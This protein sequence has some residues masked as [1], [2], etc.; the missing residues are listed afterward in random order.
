MKKLFW[1]LVIPLTVIFFFSIKRWTYALVIDAPATILNGF[2]FISSAEAWH[3]SMAIQI[4]IL[5]FISNFFIFLTLIFLIIY[6]VHK[7]FKITQINKWI[8]IPLWI[9]T[10][11][12][13]I[14][15]PIGV[16]IFDDIIFTNRNFEI[17]ILDQNYYLNWKGHK[18]PELKD[19]VK[20]QNH[21]K[22]SENEINWSTVWNS[23]LNHTIIE[24]SPNPFLDSGHTTKEIERIVFIDSIRKL[25]SK[26]LI[27]LQKILLD[28]NYLFENHN[29]EYRFVAH[30]GIV[31]F[32]KNSEMLGSLSF[33]Y[34]F[35]DIYFNPKL[36]NKNS[37]GISEI[38]R[39][40]IKLILNEK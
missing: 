32:N 14:L 4:F 22:K 37:W 36:R 12:I 30:N 9:I 2:P 40:K 1:K 21:Y 23:D 8:Y 27:E 16:L 15:A 33:N 39:E 34:D 6:L 7:I 5:E 28:T 35:K 17:Q 10:I 18:K 11:P 31:F 38:G 20:V 24:R 25:N 13:L 26:K 19:Y 29:K 3:T